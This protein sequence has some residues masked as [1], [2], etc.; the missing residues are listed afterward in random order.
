MLGPIFSAEML[1][2]G[3]RGRAH[4]LRWLYAG[5]L[6]LQLVYTYDATHA[7]VGYGQPPPAPTKAAAAFGQTFRDLVLSQ[8]FILIVLVTP[9]FVAGAITDE[10]MRG[11]LQGLL[12]AYVTPTDIVLGKL[13]ARCAQVGIL[14]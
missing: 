1:R 9:A 3:R 7:P 5:W 4:V 12:T 13:A 11:T 8:Q 14:C 6:C 2:A 10:K